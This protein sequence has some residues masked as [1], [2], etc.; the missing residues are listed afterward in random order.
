[1]QQCGGCVQAFTFPQAS[2][3][4]TGLVEVWLGRWWWDLAVSKQC[5]AQS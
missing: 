3:L 2:Q 5:S 4:V 1:M